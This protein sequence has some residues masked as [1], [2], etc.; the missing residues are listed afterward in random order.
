[1]KYQEKRIEESNYVIT[2]EGYIRNLKSGNI[3]KPKTRK[4]G[5]LEISLYI[6][7]YKY[8]YRLVHRLVAMSFIPNPEN[9]PFVNHIDG[10]K[11]NNHVDNLE[12]VTHQENMEH[13]KN[14]NLIK[15][16]NVHPRSILTD[17]IVEEICKLMEFGYRNIDISKSL[18]VKSNLISLIRHKTAWEHISCKYNIPKRSRSFSEETIRWIWEKIQ[19]GLTQSEIIAASDNKNINNDLI[20]DLRRGLYPDITGLVSRKEKIKLKNK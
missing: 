2:T 8:I 4:E 20:R 6:G 14:H 17:E 15:R 13:A 1:M 18:G 10:N 11:Q 19:E 9:K 5:Y 12:W 16:G 3:L 7:N